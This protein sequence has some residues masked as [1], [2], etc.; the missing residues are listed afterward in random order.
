MNIFTRF[1]IF[2]TALALIMSLGACGSPGISLGVGNEFAKTDDDT[3]DPIFRVGEESGNP[4]ERDNT[5]KPVGNTEL[6]NNLESFTF[7]LEGVVYR[8]PSLYA[9]FAENGWSIENSRV[10]M[11]LSYRQFLI[12]SLEKGDIQV[13]A[14]IRNF[15]MDTQP[16]DVCHV[17]GITMEHGYGS[18]DVPNVL[19]PGGITLDSSWDDMLKAYGEPVSESKLDSIWIAHY[20][21]ALDEYDTSE[22]SFVADAATGA[23]T[24]IELSSAETPAVDA[25]EYDG[26]I[27]EYITNYKAPS[28]LGGNWDAFTLKVDNKLYALP[29][30]FELLLEDDWELKDYSTQALEQIVPS[31]SQ[32]GLFGLTLVKDGKQFKVKIFNYSDSILPLRYCMIT[33]VS[34]YPTS[35]SPANVE[36]PGGLDISSTVKDIESAYGKPDEKNDN[37]SSTSYEYGE[38]GEKIYFDISNNTGKI[39]T[40]IYQHQ[41]RNLG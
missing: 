14:M 11:Q 29:V 12:V 9:E 22:I 37:G 18:N 6:G 34:V 4:V 21:Y 31:K 26:T 19:M 25:L 13:T 28:S 2:T 15:N 8:V 3:R 20:E 5:E 38:Y 32:A 7:S 16:I 41:P 1:F 40:V 24:E 27:P 39:E 35:D 10:D 36:L 33:E 17:A 23:I 30:P